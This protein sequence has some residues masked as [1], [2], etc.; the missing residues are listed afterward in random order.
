MDGPG[1]YHT[2]WCQSK[3]RQYWC[4]TILHDIA[5]MLKQKKKWCKLT[6]L[7]NRQ[8]LT[9]FEN[10]WLFPDGKGGEEEMTGSLGLTCI[11]YYIWNRK[12]TMN[13]YIAQ[14]TAQYS[15]IT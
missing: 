9:D 4:K 10:E 1:D 3:R 7:W 8:R 12:P 5:Y 14:G 11:D 2:K 6:Y 13:Y 15:V